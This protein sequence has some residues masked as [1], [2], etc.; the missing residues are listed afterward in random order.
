MTIHMNHHHNHKCTSWQRSIIVILILGLVL[1]LSVL[2]YQPAHSATIIVTST[3]DVVADDGECTLREAIAAANSDSHPWSTG[4]ECTAGSGADVV[5]VP[6]GWYFL[7]PGSALYLNSEMELVGAGQN[8]TIIDGQGASQIFNRSGT[9]GP[10]QVRDRKLQGGVASS[11]GAFHHGSGHVTTFTNVTF[12]NNSAVEMGGAL[13]NQGGDLTFI[14]C[15]VNFNVTENAVISSN[16]GGAIRNAG[17]TLT[18]IRTQFNYNSVDPD[19]IDGKGGAIFSGGSGALVSVEDSSFTG[20]SAGQGGAIYSQ[21]AT[22]IT[23]STFSNNTSTY[24]PG[25]IHSTSLVLSNSTLS[26]NINGGLSS[27][28]V[29]NWVLS[30]TFYDNDTGAPNIIKNSCTLTLK[31][32]LLFSFSG[33]SNCSGTIASGGYN[34]G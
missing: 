31:N 27:S 14:D 24:S 21:G 16:N 26:Q 2:Y 29:S 8:H 10:V 11:G 4:D 23:G 17:G 28:G 22:A 12:Y 3:A 32:T 15:I 1:S 7:S 30:S 19:E 9:A 34:L 18:V 6:T 5:N 20:N 33:S 13:V 25:A